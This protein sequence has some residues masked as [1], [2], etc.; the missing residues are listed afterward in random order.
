FFSR[1]AE[2]A[3]YV[4][5]VATVS[6]LEKSYLDGKLKPANGKYSS[7]DI[8]KWSIDLVGLSPKG[9]RYLEF[10][11]T[12]V[13]ANPFQTEK[14]RNKVH[15]VVRDG[16]GT[17]QGDRAVHDEIMKSQKSIKEVSEG[18]TK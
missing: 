3:A 7:E 15:M 9:Q 16:S 11:K 1:E 14:N 5:E 13:D 12:P 10:G 17:P 4:P 8:K 6:E 18:R 2:F